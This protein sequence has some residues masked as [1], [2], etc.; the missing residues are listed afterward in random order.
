MNRSY[1]EL[2]NA[3]DPVFF[4]SGSPEEVVLT[5]GNI[6]EGFE[7][8]TRQVIEDLARSRFGDKVQGS[9]VERNH[10]RNDRFDIRV[11]LGPYATQSQFETATR[12]I[13][14]F[15]ENELGS[16]QVT[17]NSVN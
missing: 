16:E 12:H 10:M 14:R 4:L 1:V 6:P 3:N 13:I 17:A 5:V 8:K 2:K 9:T 7:E 11:M 15:M